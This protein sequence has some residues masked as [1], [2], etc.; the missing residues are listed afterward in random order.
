MSTTEPES[1]EQWTTGDQ[2]DQEAGPVRRTRSK[3]LIL[4]ALAALA[5]LG[6][7]VGLGTTL[8]DPTMSDAYLELEDD[9]DELRAER[10]GLQAEYNA[11]EGQYD[12]VRADYDALSGD[13]EDREAEVAAREADAEEAAAEVE[14]AE[15]AVKKREEAITAAEDAKAASTISDG[16]WTVGTDIEPGTYRSAAEVGSSC[17]WGIYRSGSNGDDIIENDIPGGGRPTV[18]LSDGQDFNSTRCGSWEKQ[19]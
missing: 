6:G 3:G 1:D 17:Y 12:A 7:A 5:L 18:T 19:S 9:R 13:I 14:A 11:V 2:D 8:P 10:D 4:G 15:A 16:I